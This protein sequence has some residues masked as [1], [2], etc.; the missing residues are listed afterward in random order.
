[1]I[2]KFPRTAANGR[3]SNKKP[4]QGNVADNFF[5]S[6]L[7]CGK[8]ATSLCDAEIGDMRYL[9]VLP[10][11]LGIGSGYYQELCSLP[12]CDDC[13]CHFG[14]DTDYCPFH[15]QPANRTKELPNTEKYR[16]IREKIRHCGLTGNYANFRY[17]SDVDL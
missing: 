10:N 7:E 13:R 4:S 11:R 12:L 14:P 9:K 6:C 1:M 15:A 3:Q 8:A 2:L 16:G 17:Y 5:E